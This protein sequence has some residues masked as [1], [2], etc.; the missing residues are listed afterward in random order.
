MTRK[1]LITAT[2]LTATLVTAGLMVT[3]CGSQVQLKKPQ[4]FTAQKVRLYSWEDRCSL[5]SWFDTQPPSNDVVIEAGSWGYGPGG[6]R[7]E[8]GSTTH[9]IFHKRQRRMLRHLLKRYYR[10]VPAV[11][12]KASF[13]VTV[14][15]YRYCG[16]TRMVRG[17]EIRIDA[18][19][20]TA[21]L[22]YHP[23][24]GE[25]LL[26]QDLYATRRLHVETEFASRHRK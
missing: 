26:N 24:I 14:V 13:T 17:S 3:G 15:Y 4:E 5:Q 10:V 12:R 16:K 23:C 22:E 1:T 18:G 6:Q 25:Y 7:R 8:V 2:L 19:G 11:A 9:R 21:L 20:R